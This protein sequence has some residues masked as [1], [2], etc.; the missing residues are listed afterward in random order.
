MLTKIEI[1]THEINKNRFL[2]GLLAYGSL[3]TNELKILT[4]L[5]KLHRFNLIDCSGI[6]Q[7]YG[8][9]MAISD[10]I[11]INLWRTNVGIRCGKE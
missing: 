9:T 2:L 11:V 6:A 10:E 4:K 8:A 3:N 5:A 1:I 7:T